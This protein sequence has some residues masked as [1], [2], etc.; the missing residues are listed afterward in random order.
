MIITELNHIPQNLTLK[1]L[2]P[3]NTSFSKVQY[4]HTKTHT[5]IQITDYYNCQPLAIN[6][7]L[8]PQQITTFL[9]QNP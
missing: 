3:N 9:N 2:S 4:T 1:T 8:T 7:I 6:K 5:I